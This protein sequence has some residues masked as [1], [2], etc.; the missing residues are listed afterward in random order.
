M[1]KINANGECLSE[2][3]STQSIRVLNRV[4]LEHNTIE[5]CVCIFLVVQSNFYLKNYERHTYIHTYFI[6]ISPKGL[7]SDN[8]NY[9]KLETYNIYLNTK[10]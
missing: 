10:I 1:H 4:Y 6:F 2:R 7:F 5:K 9:K 3:L 8:P